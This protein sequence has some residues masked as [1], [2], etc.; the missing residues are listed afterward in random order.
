MFEGV[1]VPV[2]TP[3]FEDG[4]LDL[5]SLSKLCERLVSQDVAGIIPLGTTGEASALNASERHEVVAT[6]AKEVSGTDVEL[7]I[8]AG[9]NSTA[10]TL[11]RMEEYG[12]FNADAF[13]IVTPYYVRPSEEGIIAHYLTVAEKANEM[14][15]DIM[16]YNV[17]ARTGRSISSEGLI[18]CGT[19]PRI[20]GVK[21]AV[22]SLDDDT[23]NLIANT[24]DE[25]AILSGDDYL[26]APMALIG[27]KGAVAASA[28][29]ATSLWVEMIDCA[30]NG[31]AARA[32]DIHKQLLP[33]VRAGFAEPNPTVFKGALAASGEIT[34]DFVRLPL[35]PATKES[36]QALAK[37]AS[38]L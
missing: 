24:T 1:Y 22:G 32:L 30:L 6:C 27:A 19:H 37:L 12:E 34:S 23:L 25:F 26:A 14:G 15:I 36:S 4:S 8:G 18:T 20:T 21:Q 7:L 2:V 38:N 13:L 11:E 5:V 10:T 29:I 35:I 3:F 16:L 9:T 31:E 17:P 28:H 33:I